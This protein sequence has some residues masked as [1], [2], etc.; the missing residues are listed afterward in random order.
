MKKE[1]KETDGSRYGSP[2]GS[3]HDRMRRQQG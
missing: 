3:I 1:R 2:D